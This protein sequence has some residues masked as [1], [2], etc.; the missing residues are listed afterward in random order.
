MEAT[1]FIDN[2]SDEVTQTITFHVTEILKALGEDVT[3]EGLQKTPDRVAKVY[4]FLTHGKKQDDNVEELLLSATFNNDYNEIVLVKDIEFYSLCEHHL[5]PFYGKVHVGY[6][7]NGKI[8]GLSKLPR[9]VEVYARRL[10]VQEQLTIQIRDAI[11]Q[12]LEP[13]GVAVVIEAPS[14]V[15]DGARCSKT[16]IHNDH[17]CLI[18]CVSR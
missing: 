1:D 10:Q 11:Q 5:L 13:M 4:Q 16:A 2:G 12:F 17:F 7:P 18:G 3:R 9:V 15:H 8:I 14:H 6:I